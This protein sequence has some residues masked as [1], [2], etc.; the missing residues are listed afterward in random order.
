MVLAAAAAMCLAYAGRSLLLSTREREYG[1]IHY[2]L[3]P[4]RNVRSLQIAPDFWTRA[5][6]RNGWKKKTKR[7]AMIK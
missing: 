2:Y 3:V 6:P 1:I 5:L 4:R 7:I